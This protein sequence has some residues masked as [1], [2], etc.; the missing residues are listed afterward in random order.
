MP[1]DERSWRRRL[2]EAAGSWMVRDGL[3]YELP[4]WLLACAGGAVMLLANGHL[5]LGLLVAALGGL[6]A[7]AFISLIRR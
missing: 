6:A 5:V 3:K 4:L 2:D 7:A 1:A